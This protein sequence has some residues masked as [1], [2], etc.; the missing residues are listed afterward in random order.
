[1]INKIVTIVLVFFASLAFSQTAIESETISGQPKKT[2]SYNS[3][4]ENFIVAKNLDTATLK[5]S[6]E[7][8]PIGSKYRNDLLKNLNLIK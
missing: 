8:I 2:T 7:I 6:N 1:M 4:I 3:K 5:I